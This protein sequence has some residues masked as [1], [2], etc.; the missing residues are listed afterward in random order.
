MS[1]AESTA[2]VCRHCCSE[3][4]HDLGSYFGVFDGHG[5]IFSSEWL[6]K[7]LHKNIAAKREAM[8]RGWLPTEANIRKLLSGDV[9]RPCDFSCLVGGVWRE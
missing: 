8:P 3:D 5:G 9:P 2:P 7:S 6:A 4:L 1:V